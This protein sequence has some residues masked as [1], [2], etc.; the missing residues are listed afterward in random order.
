VRPQRKAVYAEVLV[1]LF[2]KDFAEGLW[3][4]ISMYCQ[5]FSGIIK[6]LP[7]YPG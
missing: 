2:D 1:I 7:R 3:L 5:F 6:G 4:S